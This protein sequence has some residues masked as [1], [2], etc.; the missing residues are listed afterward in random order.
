MGARWVRG[1]RVVGSFKVKLVVYFLLLSLL[2]IAATFWGFTSVAGQSETRRVD[3]R[4]QA[5]LRAV[6]ATYQE[7]LDGAPR[8]AGVLARARVFQK[9]IESLDL[10]ALV[11]LLENSSNVRVTAVDGFA[12]GHP[13]AFSATR[14]VPLFTRKGLIGTVTVAVPFDSTLVETL[15]TQSG[16]GP[17][18]RLVILR[19][20]S[21][22]AASPFVK[23]TVAVRA[24]RTK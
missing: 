9:P 10:P 4:L 21:I 1:Y 23:G 20:S 11:H 12:V 15:R 6:I 17:S 7:R 24:G 18:D 3:A 22:V 13:P 16:L 8:E 19:G 2:P 5:G 14:E